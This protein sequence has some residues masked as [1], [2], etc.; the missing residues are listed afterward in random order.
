MYNKC[1]YLVS[2]MIYKHKWLISSKC[3][4]MSFCFDFFHTNSLRIILKSFNNL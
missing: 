2:K 3:L 4:K 1:K